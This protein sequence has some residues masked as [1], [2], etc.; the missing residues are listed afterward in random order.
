MKLLN[1]FNKSS[2]LDLTKPLDKD[3]LKKLTRADIEKLKRMKTAADFDMK[4][5]QK[6][7]V[8]GQ[9]RKVVNELPHIP[10]IVSSM[11]LLDEIDRELSRIQGQTGGGFY[12]RELKRLRNLV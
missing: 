3:D 4:V 11:P 5:L 6:K 9:R 1:F 7:A 8:V 10:K 12:K 2:G